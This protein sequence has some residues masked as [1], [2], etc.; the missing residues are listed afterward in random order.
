[1]STRFVS[2]LLFA[3]ILGTVLLPNV[4]QA[5]WRGND[6]RHDAD[7]GHDRDYRHDGDYRHGQAPRFRHPVD[8]GYPSHGHGG[9]YQHGWHDG[10]LGWWWVVAGSWYLIN[11]AAYESAQE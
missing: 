7:R 2:K 3:V 11:R 6:N 5:E 10:H 4:S 1:M 9:G 8:Y